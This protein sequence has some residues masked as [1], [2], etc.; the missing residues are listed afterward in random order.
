[1]EL[2]VAFKNEEAKMITVKVIEFVNKLIHSVGQKNPLLQGY[3]IPLGSSSDNLRLRTPDEFDF[4]IIL[5][6]KD[7]VLKVIDLSMDERE[8]LE[9]V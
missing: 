6:L 4:N 5:L 7:I 1:M 8:T 3:A 2:T 9:A